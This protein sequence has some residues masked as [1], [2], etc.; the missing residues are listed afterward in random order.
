MAKITPQRYAQAL[1]ELTLD[2]DK[3]TLEKTIAFFVDHLVKNGQIGR[4]EQIIKAFEKYA[5][6]QN[7]LVT[8]KVT[9][10]QPLPD[11]LLKEIKKMII[12]VTAAQEVEVTTVQDEK[13]L[14]GFT[15][16]AQDWRLDASLRQKLQN[17][18]KVLI[19]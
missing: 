18:N 5:N 17:L 11:S 15:I 19:S 3:K 6:R 14:G 4:G 2:Q 8:A 10:A 16:A 9:T 12:D 7:G 1:Y 13:L